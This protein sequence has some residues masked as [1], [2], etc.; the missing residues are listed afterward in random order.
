MMSADLIGDVPVDG[1][2]TMDSNVSE[3]YGLCQTFSQEGVYDLKLTENLEVL[4]HRSGRNSISLSN[5]MCCDI[6]GKL[7][8][9][10]EI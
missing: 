4:R 6:D 10:L 8:G 1:L 5:Q 2:I 7:D 3:S 9:A